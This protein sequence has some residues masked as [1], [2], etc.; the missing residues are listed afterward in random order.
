[1]PESGASK[2][3][4]VRIHISEVK[5]GARDI[6]EKRRQSSEA[7]KATES[8]GRAPDLGERKG[9]RDRR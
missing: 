1:M 9:A 3:A 7:E 2:G 8:R 6:R 4:R 5:K